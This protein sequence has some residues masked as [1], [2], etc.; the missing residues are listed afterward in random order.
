MKS[1]SYQDWSFEFCWRLNWN[2]QIVSLFLFDVRSEDSVTWIWI[3]SIQESVS[4]LHVPHFNIEW[5]LSYT[6][7]YV[8][9]LAETIKYF[10]LIV[11]WRSGKLY[12]IWLSQIFWFIVRRSVEI[13]EEQVFINWNLFLSVCPW[14][15]LTNKKISDAENFRF[16]VS[17]LF[18][19]CHLRQVIFSGFYLWQEIFIGSLLNLIASDMLS[20]TGTVKWSILQNYNVHM[21]R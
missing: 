8:R 12:K 20:G 5:K 16:Q 15:P 7:S 21:F 3:E 9:Q 18:G 1:F 17:N 4:N 13:I 19:F 14:L 2:I 6:K 10:E 11:L